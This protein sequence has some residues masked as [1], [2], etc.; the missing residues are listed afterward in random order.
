M[1]LI[2]EGVNRKQ[3]ERGD[4]QLL[5]MGHDGGSREP[6]V[7]A[8]PS[9]RHIL[10]QLRQSLD[11]SFIEDGVFPRDRRPAFLA[12]S[13]RFV[14]DDALGHAAG[15]VA[16]VER[17]VG[18]RTAGPVAEMRVAP[19]E[20][21]CELPGVRVD[22][23]LVRI[24][25]QPALGLIWTMHTIPVELSRGDVVE[26]PVPDVLGA[27]GQDDAL[28]LAATV[29]VKQAKLDRKSVV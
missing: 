6:A 9:G 29:A 16:P 3:L 14:Y 17:E 7:C 10:A 21:P 5:E 2:D 25:A 1:A 12:P 28:D 20:A 8:A 4:A 23:Q 26:V 18:P 15:V 13:E 19:D 27:L 24:E 11:V 22:E